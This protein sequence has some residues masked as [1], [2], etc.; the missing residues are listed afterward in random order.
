MKY[1]EGHIGRVF[2]LRLEDGD[3]LPQT[4]EQFAKEK[5]INHG[6]VTMI[7]CVS[8]GEV[9]VGPRKTD[10]M[11]PDPMKVPIEGAHETIATGVLVI[12]EKT[13]QYFISWRTRT[14]RKNNNRV[15]TR[16]N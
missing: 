6:H 14:C 7:G 4:I 10:E 13:S 16:R 15:F 9:V 1:T 11:P 2:I 12:N 3:L 5:Q 8:S